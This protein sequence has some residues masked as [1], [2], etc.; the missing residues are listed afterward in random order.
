MIKTLYNVVLLTLAINFLAIAGGMGWLWKDGRL[1]KEQIARIKEVLYPAPTPVEPEDTGDPTTHPSIRLEDLLAKASGRTAAEQVEFLQ[2][3][4]DAQSAQL[5]RRHRELLDLQRQIDLAKSQLTADR[6]KLAA[7]QQKLQDEQQL[8]QKLATDK[9]FQDSLNLYQTMPSKQVKGVF[10]SLDDEIVV[11]YLQAMPPR[12][13]SK[14]IKEFK[15]PDETIRIQRVLERMRQS[16][17]PAESAKQQP[18]P[19]PEGRQAAAGP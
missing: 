3:S 9:G 8:Q 10:M 7:G 16:S 4:F 13:A 14:I 17:P 18:A 19:D 11:R 1:G 2:Q 5:D 6:A 12:T 15:T